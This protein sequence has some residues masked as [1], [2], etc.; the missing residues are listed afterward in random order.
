[1][2]STHNNLETLQSILQASHQPHLLDSHPWTKSLFVLQ[3][4]K[5]HPELMEVSPGRRLILAIAK[6]FS[7]IIPE[8]PPRHGKRLDLRWGEFGLLAA[9]YFAPIIYETPYPLSLQHSWK[10]IDQSI[11]LFVYGKPEEALSEV[12]KEPYRLVWKELSIAPENIL[13]DWHNKGMER[14][15][16]IILGQESYLSA[17]TSMPAVISID[18]GQTSNDSKGSFI[19]F[20]TRKGRF[21]FLFLSILLLVLLILGGIGNWQ[22]YKQAKMIQKDVEQLRGLIIAPDL[23]LDQVRLAGAN[24]STLRK[25]FETF[26]HKIEPSLWMG[27]FFSWIPVY[28]GDLASLSAIVKM[29]ESFLTSAEISYRVAM[30]LFGENGKFG[31]TPKSLTDA[32]VQA[33]PQLIEADRQLNLAVTT[34]GNLNVERLSPGV[35]DLIINNADQLIKVLGDALKVAEDFPR[36]MGAT[37][38]GSKFYLV[39]A[40][41]EDELRPTGGFITAVGTFRM[42][43]GGISD[44]S[45]VNS[46]D[47]DNWSKPY[48][49]APWQLQQ[50]MDTSVLVLRDL[51]WFTNYP[52]AALYAKAMYSYVDSRSLD[53]VIAFDQHFLVEIL[54]LVGPIE[55]EG[56][57]YPIDS[58]NVVTY[59]RAAKTPTAEDLASNIIITKPIFIT[60][61]ADALVGKIINGNISSERLIPVLFQLLNEHH[62][63]L[64]LEGSSISSILSHRHWDGAVQ[65][66]AGDF[67]MAVDTNVGFNKTNAEVQTTLD[68]DID[69]SKPA[70]PLSSLTVFH[71]N[72]SSAVICKQSSKMT[73]PEEIYYPISDCYWNYL[74]VY[75]VSGAELIGATPQYVPANWMIIKQDVIARVD[76]LDERIDGVQA[77]GTLQV[78]PGGESVATNFRFT[79][80]T[81]IIQSRAGQSIYRLRVQKQPGT[82]AIPIT[83]RVH[84]PNN[85]SIKSAPSGALVQNPNILYKTNLRT[86]IEIEIVFELP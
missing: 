72:N 19:P 36:L 61:I 77:F 42:E 65:P 5:E 26:K 40:Q 57:P 7:R 13:I 10:H 3:A 43:N 25:D 81:N 47:L 74:R 33:Q 48:P 29:T 63:L 24:L 41:N 53:G 82:Q 56:V 20:T 27:S 59:M 52:T 31:L 15:I 39:L 2:T 22:I 58:T 80:P 79:M 35:R 78:V 34:R 1:M 4:S 73:L 28:G 14:L 9:R 46:Y 71:K 54:N 11:L 51:S 44:L 12:E 68:Y 17:T 18:R 50:Y 75:M 84:L 55:L 45:F 69:L 76:N 70:A 6:L 60:K 32:L 86:D 67:L 66:D 16:E 23:N 21:A 85:A 64:S 37:S 49:T 38:E 83:I 8:T 30:P 62:L